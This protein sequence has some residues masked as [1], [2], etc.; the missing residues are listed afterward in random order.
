MGAQPLTHLRLVAFT[1]LELDGVGRLGPTV[2]SPM[3]RPM[4]SAGDEVSASLVAGYATA[5]DVGLYRQAGCAPSATEGPHPSLAHGHDIDNILSVGVPQAPQ[6]LMAR[7]CVL[8][9]ETGGVLI[10]GW[11]VKWSA[12]SETGFS[13]LIAVEPL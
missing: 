2:A 3:G 12:G 7:A 10:P 6:G 5:D 1:Q 8:V 4:V 11:F 9:A 13:Y